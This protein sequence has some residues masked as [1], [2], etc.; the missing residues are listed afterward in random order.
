MKRTPPSAPLSALPRALV[1]AVFVL[2][3]LSFSAA[4]DDDDPPPYTPPRDAAADSPVGDAG[5]SDAAADGKADGAGDTQAAGERPN[6]LLIVASGRKCVS[7]RPSPSMPPPPAGAT[8]LRPTPPK[9][10]LA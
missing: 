6:I 5:K 4:C 2:S 1:T 8:L 10:S 7:A 9:R 3:L